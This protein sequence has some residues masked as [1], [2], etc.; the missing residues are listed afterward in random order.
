MVVPLSAVFNRSP[1]P[2]WGR[3][4][5]T[6]TPDAQ[7]GEVKNLH[8]PRNRYASLLAAVLLAGALAMTGCASAAPKTSTARTAAS[9]GTPP[10]ATGQATTAAAGNVHIT[11]YSI[12]SDGPHFRVILT[13]AVGD[14]GP[15]V[16]VYPNGKIDPRHTSEMELKL[17]HGSFRLSIASLGQKLVS[18]FR[19]FPANPRTCS[20]TV[21][22]AAAA[23]IVTGSGTGLY[24]GISG[25]F[26]LTTTID[27]VDAQPVCNGTSRFL[28]QVIVMAGSGTISR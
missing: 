14:Y 17:T 12:N 3:P 28:S 7:T 13:G 8:W 15:G 18:A 21:T 9:G 26:S 2:H 27:E 4:P 20:G 5:A 25:S 23:P 11:A 16:T 6:V 19:H 24:R 22:V 1:L 10:A